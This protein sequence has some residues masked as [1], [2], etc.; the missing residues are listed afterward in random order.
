MRTNWNIE[1]LKP[2]GRRLGRPIHPDN[3]IEHDPAWLLAQC[4][5]DDK[6]V[7]TIDDG[8][9]FL[10]PLFVHKGRL[11]FQIGELTLGSLSVLRHVIVG[12]FTNLP[13]CDWSS[14]I[15]SL[16]RQ[17][18]NRSVVFFLGIVQDECLDL[19][20]R[21][22]DFG[23]RFLVL[24]QGPSYQRRMCRIGASLDEY[25]QTLPSKSRQDVRRSLR[26][27][28]NEYKGRFAISVAS[29]YAEVGTFLDHVEPVSEQTYQGRLLGLGINR[30]GHIGYKALQGSSLG[31]TRCLLL[32]VDDKPVAW[33][34]GFLYKNIFY[35]HHIGFDPHFRRFH[36]GVV[37]HLETIRYLSNEHPEIDTLDMLY[38]DND[39]KRKAG[40]ES[41]RERNVYLFQKTSFGIF[42]WLILKSCN[43]GSEKAGK[44]LEYL[45]L[46]NL[47]R[48]IIRR[49]AGS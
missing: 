39:F 20:L 14:A 27:F 8:Q 19:T 30:T 37:M 7:L 13:S 32:T 16:C 35:S 22:S 5:S 6:Y 44:F 1:K 46:K 25:L 10:F 28:E 34:I 2:G 11:S 29:S 36:P 23:K 31:Y 15:S 17:L 18:P 9:E 40:T 3:V 26:R 48:T 4:N 47:I 21:S 45:G 41:R 42:A 49:T 33:R 12:N 38:G 43:F 24:Q